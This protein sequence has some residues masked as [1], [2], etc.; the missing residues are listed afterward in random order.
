MCRKL[1]KV[2]S[3]HG[4]ETTCIDYEAAKS[5]SFSV[6]PPQ[7]VFLTDV[8]PAQ[9]DLIGSLPKKDMVVIVLV[10]EN[11][12]VSV[13]DLLVAGV[14]DILSASV[15]PSLLTTRLNFI[16]Q[17]AALRAERSHINTTCDHFYLGHPLYK[18]H[19]F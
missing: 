6:K 4:Y 13:E 3:T 19:P 9:L 7:L 17:R 18:A 14:D 8:T 5:W 15:D 16:V 10:D 1:Q 2:L 12:S 11:L